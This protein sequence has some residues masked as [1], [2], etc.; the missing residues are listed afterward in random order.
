MARQRPSR[1]R[2]GQRPLRWSD[3]VG[4]DI[5]F[6]ALLPCLPAPR[7]R[8]TRIRKRSRSS[9]I[10]AASMRATSA[11]TAANAARASARA[12]RARRNARRMTP[13]AV[14]RDRTPRRAAAVRVSHARPVTAGTASASRPPGMASSARALGPASPARRMP[15][16]RQSVA[17]WR[18]VPRVRAA[19]SRARSVWGRVSSR[20]ARRHPQG[21]WARLT[22]HGSIVSP[23]R[24]QRGSLASRLPVRSGAPPSPHS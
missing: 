15:I 23:A 19:R 1:R 13:A 5:A 8:S 24:S 18:R 11:R 2:H 16:A 10:S 20:V 6:A 7:P 9:T 17:R 22:T 12:G 21:D 14:R 4:F 3:A